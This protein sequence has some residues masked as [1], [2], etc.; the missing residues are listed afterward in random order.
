[1]EELDQGKEAAM[2]TIGDP[3]IYSTYSYIQTIL[4]EKGYETKT[5]SG[6]PSFCAAA[7]RLNIPLASA[8]EAI[9]IV[10][11]NQPGGSGLTDQKQED[12]GRIDT[13]T[14]IYMKSGRQLRTLLEDLRMESLNRQLS[15][16]IVSNCGMENEQ[17]R[18]WTRE[19]LNLN[20]NLDTIA[21][22]GYLTIV[23]V[24]IKK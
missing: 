5:I 2:L 12:I 18:I 16:Y 8:S 7:A 19:D 24:M 22:S 11:G 17:I 20:E 3:S 15:V 10:S 9:H 6:V 4:Q 21:E 13:G 23:I 14:R 1:M